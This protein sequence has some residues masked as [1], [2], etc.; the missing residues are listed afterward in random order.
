[1]CVEVAVYG[2]GVYVYVHGR[3]LCSDTRESY[4]FSCI[5]PYSNDKGTLTDLT[6]AIYL[7]WPSSSRDAPVSFSGLV[8]Q[9][10]A[11]VSVDQEWVLATPS[12][13]HA[14][15]A[16]TLTNWASSTIPPL[17]FSDSPVHCSLAGFIIHHFCCVFTHHAHKCLPI[18]SSP[19]VQRS[20]CVFILWLV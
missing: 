5:P 13:L 4:T 2:C 16:R 10:C 15:T 12:G 9:A 19:G 1:M 17:L 6:F 14:Y 8:F 18:S 20:P 7:G 11:A 3:L